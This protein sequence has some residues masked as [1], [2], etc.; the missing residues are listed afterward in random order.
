MK[1]SSKT[2]SFQAKECTD[3]K[4]ALYIRGNLSK[5]CFLDEENLRMPL[6]TYSSQANF[7]I[8]L[9]TEWFVLRTQMEALSKEQYF[10]D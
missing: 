8:I 9:H 5:T 4:M 7:K 6:T 1:G 3:S 2:V 10:E